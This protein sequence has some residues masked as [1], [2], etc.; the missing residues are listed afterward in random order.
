MALSLKPNHLTRYKDIAALLV[1][2]GR[3]GALRSFDPDSPAPDDP[4][5]DEDARR[6]ADDLEAMGPTFIKLGQ[7]LST[8]ADLLPPAYLEALSR[9]Q[10]DV[11]PVSFEVI[12][13]AVT[14]EI[15]ARISN[16]FQS[17][18]STPRASASLGQVHRAVLRDGRPVAVKVQ[19]PGIRQR[20]VDDME[21]I[22]ELAEFLDT[23]TGVGRAY[24]FRGMVEEFRRSI[25]AELDYRLEAANLRL[26]GSQLT[27]YQRIVV[28]QP[29][30]DYT[31]STV[32]TMDLV[33]GR[34]VGSLG[35][36]ATLETDRCGLAKDLFDAYLDQIL[37]HG[38][39]HADPHPGNVLLTTD[40]R[41]A[42]IDLG[43]VVR[44]APELQDDLV[45]LLL[46]LSEG[47]GTD[48]SS[49]LA[50]LGE[51]RENWDRLRFEREIS[52]LVQRNQAVTVGQLE[53]GR[54][55]GELARIAG[56]CGLRP[57]VELTMLGK[58]LLNLDQVAN[59]VDPDF[60]PNAA[61]QD[62]VGEIMRRKMLQ[63]ASPAHLLS[64]AMDAKEF[65][66]KLPAR[67]NK[68]MDAL[69]EGQMTLNIQGIDEKE[70][71]RG[72]QKLANRVT[73]GLVIAALI[74][75][76][77]MLMQ[78]DTEAKLFGYPSVAI[79]CFLAAAAAGVWLVVTSLLHD[80]PQ[81]RHRRKTSLE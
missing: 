52:A 11:E 12:E 67:V 9:L 36:L 2:Y 49:I 1:K 30:D 42:L 47:D 72:I 50:G 57:P 78:I 77:A 51:K 66:E 37:V 41:L 60:D 35:P 46:A 14:R 10:D 17:F 54:M 44:I 8:R 6:L 28:P 16:A 73:A 76:A 79:V 5:I 25:M 58:T 59:K 18:E 63:S 39:V 33:D 74:V 64:A 26:L 13:E 34:N 70:L 19:R 80:L 3:S 56:D 22:E 71:M 62:H 68:V 61:I 32:L 45:R 55:V 15:G 48:V 69:A 38:F 21:V 7:L 31:T 29:I 43:M 53:A 20:I 27:D 24:G 23:H 40:G 81:R 75:G 65:V 4:T